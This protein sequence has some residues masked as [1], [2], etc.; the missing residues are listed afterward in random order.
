MNVEKVIRTLGYIV[1]TALW[2]PV[3]V[4]AFPITFIAWLVM[5]IRL[6]LGAKTGMRLY[7]QALMHGIRHD[8]EFIRTGKWY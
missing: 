7:R 4:L 1:Y 5:A 3:I 6:D 2:L 8:A